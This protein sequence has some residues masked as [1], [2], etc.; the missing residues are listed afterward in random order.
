M[1]KIFNIL[2]LLIIILFFLAIS[3]YYYSS[4]NME[5]KNYNRLNINE[6]L[7]EKIRDLPVLAND[8]NNVIEFNNS[9][10]NEITNEK[11]RSF[12]NLLKNK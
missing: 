9:F 5:I 10:K 11:K 12:W 2:I 6:I 1:Y 3:K 8:T 7:K 4:K